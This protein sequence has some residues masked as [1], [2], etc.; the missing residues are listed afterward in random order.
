[1]RFGPP[2]SYVRRRD[3]ARMAYQVVGD[4]D[5]DLVLLFG[6]P[7]CWRRPCPDLVSA[8]VTFGSHPAT[9]RDDYPWGSTLEE[10]ELLLALIR[11]AEAFDGDMVLSMV[12]PSEAIDP[13]VRHW[14]RVFAMSGATLAEQYEGIR[15]LGRAGTGE[16]LCSR[17][18]KDLVAGSGFSFADRGTHSLKGFP[19]DWQL[20]AVELAEG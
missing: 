13:S 5:R 10:H 15:V 20:C 2:F 6:W 11:D 12:A 17:T 9:L 4:G 3:G 16:I 18:V 7:C 19:D 8:V 1:M 14:F